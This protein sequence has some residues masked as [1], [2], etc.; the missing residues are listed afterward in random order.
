MPHY[1][2]MHIP[3]VDW[4][5]RTIKE[6]LLPMQLSSVAEQLGKEA[7]LTESFAL[8]GHNVSFAELKGICEWQMVRGIN[9][10]CQ[11]LEGYSLRE[12]R[13]RDYPPAMYLQQPWWK[14][15]G[16]FNEAMARIGM[17]MGEGE[18]VV[19]VLLLHPQTTAWTLYDDCQ[20][21]GL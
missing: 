20:N 2:Y 15:Y 9:L 18:A 14:D 6:T 10:L 21:E 19:E 17:I 16:S 4:L 11:H 5:G 1:E 12:I 13:K 3:G 8:C 7:V